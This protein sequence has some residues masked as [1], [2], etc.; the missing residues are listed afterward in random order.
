MQNLQSNPEMRI[1]GIA[2]GF[3]SLIQV[4]LN[5]NI[6]GGLPIYAISHYRFDIPF[7]CF[8]IDNMDKE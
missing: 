3:I 8:N 7:R 2:Q 1:D 6:D 4:R 5:L